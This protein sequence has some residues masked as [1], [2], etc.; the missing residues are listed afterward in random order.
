MDCMSA[1][2]SSFMV[3]E[4]FEEQ[5]LSC[6]WC[7]FC[8]NL[9]ILTNLMFRLEHNWKSLCC[10]ASCHSKVAL[11]AGNGVAGGLVGK[12]P[13]ALGGT[14]SAARWWHNKCPDPN[15]ASRASF[16]AKLAT[17]EPQV[18]GDWSSKRNIMCTGI[19]VEDDPFAY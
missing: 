4:L 14:T 9:I 19:D 10:K 6:V 17:T 11:G 2:L 8:L 7:S 15:L 1:L 13:Q 18:Y 12:V 5:V 3:F 16:C